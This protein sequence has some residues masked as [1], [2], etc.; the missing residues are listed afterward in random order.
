MLNCSW[1]LQQVQVSTSTRTWNLK[2]TYQAVLPVVL[3]VDWFSVSGIPAVP[4]T[5]K[6]HSQASSCTSTSKVLDR[7]ILRL[8]IGRTTMMQLLL[9]LLSRVEVVLVLEHWHALLQVQV[10]VQVEQ[11][12]SFTSST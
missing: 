6:V 7:H 9:L 11:W 8:L 4:V 12:H 3:L 5:F 2:Y 1:V 10:Q